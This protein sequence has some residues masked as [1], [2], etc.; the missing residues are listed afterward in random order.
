AQALAR[1]KA[2][3]REASRLIKNLRRSIG[4]VEKK[5]GT[6]A[7]SVKSWKALTDKQGGYITIRGLGDREVGTLLRKLQEIDTYV[8]KNVNGTKKMIDRQ[9]KLY[10]EDAKGLT[11]KQAVARLNS[12]FR[13]SNPHELFDEIAKLMKEQ[14]NIIEQMHAGTYD[15]AMQLASELAEASANLSP[16]Q[17]ED[18]LIDIAEKLGHATV[19][20]SANGTPLDQI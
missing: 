6:F 15:K 17:I 16:D 3:R 19:V 10:G 2:E 12:K 14:G 7:Q 13:N 9:L 5:Y 1:A 4:N 11:P 18:A 8:T 20:E